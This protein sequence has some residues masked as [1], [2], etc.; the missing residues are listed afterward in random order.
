M[1]APLLN[2]N[3]SSMTIFRITSF[4]VFLIFLTF[5]A[6]SQELKLERQFSHYFGD[7]TTDFT[8]ADF[9]NDGKAND[10]LFAIQDKNYMILNTENDLSSNAL[11]SEPVF[12]GLP[13]NT[14]TNN[15][16]LDAGDLNG[17]GF[18]DVIYTL[19]DENA[20]AGI[21]KNDGAGDFEL[22]AELEGIP[23]TID[24]KV[25]KFN[26]DEF[27]DIAVLADGM[28][29]IFTGSGDFSF[30]KWLSYN[31][32][33]SRTGAFIRVDNLDG[34]ALD[35]IVL[36]YSANG[37]VILDLSDTEV[38]AT[39]LIDT[40]STVEGIAIADLDVDGSNDIVLTMEGAETALVIYY[41]N[42]SL[43]ITEV[44]YNLDINPNGINILIKDLDEDGDNDIVTVTESLSSLLAIFLNEG[45]RTFS[46]TLTEGA[47]L[48]SITAT[49]GAIDLPI[50]AEFA[51][52]PYQVAV[53][54]SQDLVVNFSFFQTNFENYASREEYMAPYIQSVVPVIL[55][56]G[57]KATL[58]GGSQATT[59]ITFYEKFADRDFSGTRSISLGHGFSAATYADLNGDGYN[60]IIAGD[61]ETS[62]L[63]SDANG[64]Y[65]LSQTF[66]E[67]AT[68]ERISIGDVDG[69]GDIDMFLSNAIYFNDGAGSFVQEQ[70]ITSNLLGSVLADIDNDD[71]LDLIAYSQDNSLVQVYS[72]NGSGSFASSGSINITAQKIEGIDFDEDG[73]L[74]LVAADPI[75]DILYLL[76]NTDGT[77]TIGQTVN[78]ST[79][80]GEFAIMDIT[81]D[82]HPEIVF[83]VTADFLNYYSLSSEGIS[84]P[85]QTFQSMIST[86]YAVYAEDIL[87]E[88]ETGMIVGGNDGN[89]EVYT[90]KLQAGIMFDQLLFEYSASQIDFSI[91]TDPEN[92]DATVTFNGESLRPR[93]AGAYIV[94]ATIQDDD[95]KGSLTDTL[96]IIPDTIVAIIDDATKEYGEP[97]PE[98][99]VTYDAFLGDDTESSLDQGPA[100]Q[101]EATEVSDVGTYSITSDTII[102]NNYIVT[103]QYG[104]LTIEKA[105]LD[106]IADD[107]EIIAEEDMPE[108]TISYSGFK[109]DD[110]EDDLDNLPTASVAIQS[111]EEHGEFEIVVEGG[112]DNNYAYNYINGT[113]VIQKPVSA[114]SALY[115]KVFPNPVTD[116]ILIEHAKGRLDFVQLVDS[117]GK[118]LKQS[119]DHKLSLK[120]LNPGVY[121][122][123]V[124]MTN[125]E[126]SVTRIIKE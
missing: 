90:N 54:S 34:D 102:D 125:G 49:L 65:T 31:I 80:V 7:F 116:E 32:D 66:D 9:N 108:F 58:I 121:L 14:A 124:R 39:T 53:L 73:D 4:T 89:V 91:T 97:N 6:H 88:G 36:A 37:A 24:V 86:G 87:A 123:N 55:K 16:K 78:A 67:Y 96:T 12:V 47:Y 64:D 43:E 99:T 63:L 106:V 27:A 104:T 94:E 68:T 98:F 60:D 107:Q 112:D 26:D 69:D 2:Q 48:G 74:D 114:N 62:I 118:V 1:F 10:F 111:T 51:D 46:S 5:F 71:D 105:P 13:D 84:E 19:H 20:T 25:G 3:Y 56:S 35:E 110:T 29:Q 52:Y 109:N 18:T 126:N 85:S 22:I 44:K 113:L 72:N 81:G 8:V 100:I 11:F 79:E 115:I 38:T 41:L 42:P 21:L 61:F 30:S 77:F 76:T 23:Y 117:S 70:Y 103:V 82:E 92:L 75:N 28:V 50:E 17:D 57:E 122:L 120:S 33:D 59:Y 45:S 83:S 101:T 40:E 119:N 93:D 95:Y 15:R